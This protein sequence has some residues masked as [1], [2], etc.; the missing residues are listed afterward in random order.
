LVGQETAGWGGVSKG[1]KAAGRL[2]Y[3]LQGNLAKRAEELAALHREFHVDPDRNTPFWRAHAEL[4]GELDDWSVA[5][6]NLMRVDTSP[7]GES[8]CSAWWNLS[9]EEVR[10]VCSWQRALHYAELRKLK[11]DAVIFFTGPNYDYCVV[12]TFEL[13]T[14]HD[15]SG[16]ARRKMARV[17]APILL[18][19]CFRTYHPAYL[20]RSNQWS[21]LTDLAALLPA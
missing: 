15:L 6:S 21:T 13:A 1:D 2:R 11:P 10:S 3:W 4:V 14:F 8:S 9:C 5:W 17:S 19:A 7:L 20:K 12:R 18:E 16:N